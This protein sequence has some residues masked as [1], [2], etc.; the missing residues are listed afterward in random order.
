MKRYDEAIAHVANQRIEI[1]LDDGVKMNYAK[2]RDVEVAQEGKS[3]WQRYRKDGEIDVFRKNSYT[4]L[5][6]S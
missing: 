6:S 5:Q 4:E 1:D 3:F 2:F